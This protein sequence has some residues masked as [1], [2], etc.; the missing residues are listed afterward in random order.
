M[1]VA[2]VMNERP[3]GSLPGAD[4]ELNML[5]P[6]SLLLGCATSTNPGGWHPQETSNTSRFNLIQNLADEFWKRWT[7]LCAPSLVLHPKWHTSQRNLKPG[8]VVLVF[9]DSSAIRGEYRLAIVRQVYAGDDDKVRKVSLAY[10]TYKVGEKVADYSGAKDQV[11]TRSVQRLVLIVP[12]D[13]EETLV[14]D[15]IPSSS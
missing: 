12:V 13:Q 3:I 4:S 10:K 7:E 2:N 15:D 11:I 5:T 14:P 9:D 1:E 8:D 6:N